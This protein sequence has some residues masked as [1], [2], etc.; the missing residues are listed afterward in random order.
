MHLVGILESWC[1][2]EEER[3]VG[4]NAWRKEDLVTNNMG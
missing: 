1:E 3:G 4:I 2:F